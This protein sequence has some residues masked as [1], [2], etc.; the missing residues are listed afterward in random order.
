MIPN[1]APMAAVYCLH[2]R[3][4]S[5]ASRLFSR[6]VVAWGDGPLSALVPDSTSRLTL[7]SSAPDGSAFLGLW[8][9]GWTPSHEE[10]SCLL[11]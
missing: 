3:T 5:P 7:A 4:G 8:Q 10:M 1:S 9:G 2:G 6:P 11:D